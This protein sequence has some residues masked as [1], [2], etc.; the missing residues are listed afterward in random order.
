MKSRYSSD[1]DSSEM[2]GMIFNNR[3]VSAGYFYSNLDK[4]SM[5]H[6]VFWMKKGSQPEIASWYE[7]EKNAEQARLDSIND[8]FAKNG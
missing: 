7:A 5:A 1:P 2:L 4:I 8:F 3:L 6:D